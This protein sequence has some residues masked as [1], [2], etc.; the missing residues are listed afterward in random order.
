MI[1]FFKQKPFLRD[2]IPDNCIDIHS[3]LLPGIDDGAATMEDSI[4]LI[5]QMSALGFKN[6]ITTPH[7]ITN[8]WDNN[9]ESI[10]RI[11]QE[12]L[13][14]I[15]EKCDIE[16]FNIGC[17]YM[18]DSYFLKRLETEKLLTIK[19]N[20]LLVEMSY[21]SPPFQLYEILF[22]I[23]LAGYKPI[24]AHP[25]R[26]LYYHNNFNEYDKLKKTG[27][28]FQLNL[29]STVEYY[30][31]NIAK[32]TDKLLKNEYYDFVGSD[33]HHQNHINSFKNKIAVK[34]IETLKHVILKNLSFLE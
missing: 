8:V 18:M 29:L 3:H 21:L 33:I 26:Y 13:E 34:N 10:R 25:E 15:Q 27:C 30:G 19:D 1:H 20:Y 14:V 24:L 6:I 2:L 22:E 4:S 28:H 5:S 7:I 16:T 17:E 9:E 11:H 32:I 12:T 23:Q 31:K